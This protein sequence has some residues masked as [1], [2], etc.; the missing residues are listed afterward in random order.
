MVLT[1]THAN[2]ALHRFD[3]TL[4]MA[5]LPLKGNEVPRT[6]FDTSQINVLV[7]AP[8][9]LITKHDHLQMLLMEGIMYCNC[10][11]LSLRGVRLGQ[12]LDKF[13]G[14]KI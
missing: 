6:V 3:A 1:N 12:M 11:E 4:L 8:R 5:S 9:Y 10:V 14:Q 13:S 7:E 2:V